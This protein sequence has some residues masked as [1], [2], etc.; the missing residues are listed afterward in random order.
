MVRNIKKILA[1]ATG[2]EPATSAVTG[3]RLRGSSSSFSIN[4]STRDADKSGPKNRDS[5]LELKHAAR[6]FPARIGAFLSVALYAAALAGCT[7]ANADRP[8]IVLDASGN[9]A[10]P[11]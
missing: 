5:T 10:V 4:D 2:L 1:G 6:K 7:Q 3:R 9:V 11:R 8:G